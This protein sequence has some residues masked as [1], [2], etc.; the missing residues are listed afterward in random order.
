MYVDREDVSMISLTNESESIDVVDMKEIEKYDQLR[1]ILSQDLVEKN[2]YKLKLGF[3]TTIRERDV[4]SY[5][6]G[7]I[8]NY[9]K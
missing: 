4:N 6:S 1:I 7:Y 5:D 2:R 3:S 9:S 8:M